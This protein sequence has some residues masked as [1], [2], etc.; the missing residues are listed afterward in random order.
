MPHSPRWAE[1]RLW[2]ANSGTGEFGYIDAT[3]GQFENVCFCPGY[4]RGVSIHQGYAIVGLSKPRYA[5][6]SGLP[7]DQT[8][9][10]KGKA[11][12]CGVSIID[13]KRGEIIH[14]LTFEGVVSELYDVV[15]LPQTKR[16]SLIGF[17][18]EQIQ[19]TISIE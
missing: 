6:F 18:N 13:L 2:L 3:T 12:L 15:S 1:G 17:R 8:L 4:L 11:P 7:I 14:Q 19:R 10:K 16:P 9:K 5:A